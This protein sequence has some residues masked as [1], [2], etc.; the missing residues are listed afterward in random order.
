MQVNSERCLG[1]ACG[2]NRY[3]SRVFRCPGLIW[4][5]KSGRAQIDE[6]ICVGCG[7]CT[8]VCPQQAIEKEERQAS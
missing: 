2:C 3:C 8:Q 5:E 4:D 6:V 7:V 1:E